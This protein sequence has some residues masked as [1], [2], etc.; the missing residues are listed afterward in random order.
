M[1]IVRNFLLVHLVLQGRPRDQ[2]Q[3]H[4]ARVRHHCR[5]HRTGRLFL[6]HQRRDEHGML[7]KFLG[8]LFPTDELGV[9]QLYGHP[10]YA[11]VSCKRLVSLRVVVLH[12]ASP[13][14]WRAGHVCIATLAHKRQVAEDA[15]DSMRL[16]LLKIRDHRMPLEHGICACRLWQRLS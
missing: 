14:F 11:P 6:L 8:T 15:S 4:R 13:I 3:R 1:G 16:V 5:S 2:E 12:I 7:A 9:L 10:G